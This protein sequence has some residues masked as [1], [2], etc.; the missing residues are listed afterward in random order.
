MERKFEKISFSQFKKDIANDEKLYQEIML[1]KR[2]TMHSAGYDF[3]AIKDYTIKPGEIVKIPTC[4]K[5]KC[6]NNEFLLVC[7]RSGMGF[8][9]NIRMCN[10]V[11]II[12]ADYYDNENNEGHIWVALQ[13]H[14][15]KEYYIKEKDAYAQGIFI[16]YLTTSDDEGN[17]IVRKGSFGSTSKK[18][19]E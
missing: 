13:N 3:F 14:G 16:P 8:K 4:Y 9:S 15:E 5:A 12:D 6:P 18:G 7:V 10:Q 19:N 1:P 17:K 2:A 11:G